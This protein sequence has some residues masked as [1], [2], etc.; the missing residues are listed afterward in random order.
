MGDEPTA[1]GWSSSAANVEGE[2]EKQDSGR[3]GGVQNL[4][5]TRYHFFRNPYSGG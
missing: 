2:A 3:A 5:I 4:V 1:G